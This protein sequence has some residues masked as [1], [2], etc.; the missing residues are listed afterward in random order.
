MVKC[1]KCPVYG[2][3]KTTD[4]E[5]TLWWHNHEGRKLPESAAPVA[6][7]MHRRQEKVDRECPLLIIVDPIKYQR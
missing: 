3:C 6:L 4:H 2:D 1:K 5:A 7:E